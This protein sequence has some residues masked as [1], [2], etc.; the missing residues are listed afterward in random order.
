MCNIFTIDEKIQKV[1]IVTPGPCYICTHEKC[2]ALL[3]VKEK[4]IRLYEP[5][6]IKLDGGE[7]S[8]LTTYHFKTNGFKCAA[9]NEWNG[10]VSEFHNGP[11]LE[12]EKCKE[13]KNNIFNL[14][15]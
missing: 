3:I 11:A 9:C 6:S 1:F 12:C 14:E 10:L 2:K 13:Y 8:I 7:I 4:S 5:P 15:I